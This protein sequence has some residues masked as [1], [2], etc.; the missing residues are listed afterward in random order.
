[1]NPFLIKKKREKNFIIK[2]VKG[3]RPPKDKTD[4]VISKTLIGDS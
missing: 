3:G 1:M 2:P 4:K